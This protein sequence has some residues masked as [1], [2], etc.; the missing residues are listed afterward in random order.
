MYPIYAYRKSLDQHTPLYDQKSLQS[1]AGK[2]C[3]RNSVGNRKPN[4][5]PDPGAAVNR[6]T[7]RRIA[8]SGKNR[9]LVDDV[10]RT[11]EFQLIHKIE[12]L[13]KTRGFAGVRPEW[14]FRLWR[15]DLG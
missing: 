8:S 15:K 3:D 13:C 7:P 11:H 2:K 14:Q 4:T 12:D 10:D 5:R 1:Q 6:R 9:L